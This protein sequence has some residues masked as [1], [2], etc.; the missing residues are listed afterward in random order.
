MAYNMRGRGPRTRGGMQQ[1]RMLDQVSSRYARSDSNVFSCLRYLRGSGSAS[2]SEALQSSDTNSDDEQLNISSVH[3]TRQQKK[4]KFNS[5]SGGGSKLMDEGSEDDAV[6]YETLEAD[7]KLNLILSKVTLNE[8]RFKKLENICGSAVKHSKRLSQV[9]TVMKSQE[10][11]IRL[12]EYKSID[13]E[14]RSRRNNVLFYG[15]SESRNED[16]KLIILDK[17]RQELDIAISESDISRAHRLG[18]YVMSK[19]RPVIV[20]FQSYAVAES[21]IKQAYRLK[22]TNFSISRDFPLEI[23]RARSTLWPEYKQIKVP[24]SLNESGYSIPSKVACEWAC[25]K[26]LISRMGRGL[27]RQ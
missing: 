9:E 25:R 27:V 10:D 19:K 24:E 8:K 16:C 21:I 2:E 5:S 12:L 6:D 18:R 3:V 20:A 11:R 14:A 4:R 23:T 7:E 26:G 22:G 1:G 17:L 13:L 15:L